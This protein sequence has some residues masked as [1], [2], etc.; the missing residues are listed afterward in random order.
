MVKE[1][2]RVFVVVKTQPHP[3]ETYRETV[4]TAGVTEDGQ[5][6]RL[7]PFPYRFM[8]SQEKFKKYQW[9]SVDVEKS[10]N[11]PRPESYKA[12][13][14]TL[15]VHEEIKDWEKRRKIIFNNKVYTMCELKDIKR[16]DLSLAIVKPY[17]VN[18]K[19]SPCKPE[20]GEKEK[21]IM[22]RNY[23]FDN[24]RP[25]LK[26]VPYNFIYT[27]RCSYRQCKR[28]AQKIN[29]W[30]ATAA[31]WNFLKNSA[32]EKNAL[33]KMEEKFYHNICSPKIDLHFFVG[34]H[35]IHKA[36]LLIGIWY[37]KNLF[38]YE[39]NGQNTLWGFLK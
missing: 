29:D 34:R 19:I 22:R 13:P 11:D 23:L 32:S 26:K 6:I 2:K 8:A 38:P 36:W 30:E 24:D 35:A 18:F 1:R 20:W 4:C 14:D 17:D 21:A 25:L 15:E 39:A 27:Y 7:Y 37:A 16:T 12:F 3:S 31:Y 5:F 33:Q 9:I 28:H 10:S